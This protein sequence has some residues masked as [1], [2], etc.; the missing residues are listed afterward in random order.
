MP[1]LVELIKQKGR[2]D[3]HFAFVPADRHKGVPYLPEFSLLDESDTILANQVRKGEKPYVLLSFKQEL[4][5]LEHKEGGEPD[6]DNNNKRM[7][8]QVYRYP[9]KNYRGLMESIRPQILPESVSENVQL[10]S[11][12]KAKKHISDELVREVKQLSEWVRHN[13]STKLQEKPPDK[14]QFPVSFA[15]KIL[16]FVVAII[17][18]FVGSFGVLVYKEVTGQMAL[19]SDENKKIVRKNTEITKKLNSIEKSIEILLKPKSTGE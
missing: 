18:L 5:L 13:E 16:W 12:E 9:L 19:L 11:F 2:C 3:G 15:P 1:D 7:G 8:Y 6:P 10:D 17:T 4:L 14:Y